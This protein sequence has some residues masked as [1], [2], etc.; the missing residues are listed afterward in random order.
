MPVTLFNDAVV[1][2]GAQDIEQLVVQGHTTQ[3]Q[4]LQEWQASSGDPLARLTG[5]GRLQIGSFDNGVMATDESLIEAHRLETDA[6]APK[7][8]LHLKGALSGPLSG[9]VAWVVQELTLKGSSG[10]AACT[11]S[12]VFTTSARSSMACCVICCCRRRAART[13]LRLG[14]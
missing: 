10:V 12:S 3:T 9:L 4:P 5:D 11:C 7:R 8:G 13:S 14:L 2:D 6:D 1:I